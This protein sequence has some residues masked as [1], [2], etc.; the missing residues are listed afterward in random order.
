MLSS[1]AT[2]VRRPWKDVPPPGV[3]TM[4]SEYVSYPSRKKVRSCVPSGTG[5]EVNGV[6]PRKHPP[7]TTDAPAGSEEIVMAPTSPPALSVDGRLEASET[8]GVDR[9]GAGIP[10]PRV[11]PL[12]ADPPPDAAGDVGREP[13]FCETS[14]G[15]PAVALED[16][17][18]IPGGIAP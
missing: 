5:T 4:D 15:E 6:R 18:S 12:E 8:G 3:T 10:D 17:A 2:G 7:M 16:V 9:F 14:R 13:A 1:P 11:E